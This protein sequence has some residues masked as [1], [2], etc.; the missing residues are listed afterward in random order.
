MDEASLPAQLMRDCHLL[1][2]LPATTVL[3][4]RNAL[5]PWFILVPDTLLADVLDLADEHR[6]AVIDDCAAVSHFIKEVLGYEKVNFAGL[7]N[8]VPE[9]HLHVIGRRVGD[10]CWPRPV[11]GNLEG[12]ADYPLELLQ[13]YQRELETMAGLVPAQL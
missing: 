12:F 10:P 9:M 7:G 13:E 11:W 2:S 5:L 3:L 4:Q 6:Q 1:G 8:V